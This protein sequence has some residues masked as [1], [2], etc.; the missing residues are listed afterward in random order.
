MST[1]SVIQSVIVTV[2]ETVTKIQLQRV[3][4]QLALRPWELQ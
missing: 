4:I 1:V 2:T 3:S